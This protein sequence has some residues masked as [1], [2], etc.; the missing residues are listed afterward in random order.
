MMGSMN[1]RTWATLGSS[2][3]VIA[4]ISAPAQAQ[5][6]AQASPPQAA[7]PAEDNAPNEIIVTA[8]KRSE[9]LSDVGLTIS[10][11][12]GDT[13]RQAAVLSAAD[14]PRLVPGLTYARSNTGLPVYTLRGVG[15][16]ETSLAAYPAVT[17]YVDQ[18]PLAFPLLTSHTGLDL[19]RVEVLKGP[20]GILFGQNSTGGAID[21]VAAKPTSTP[22][23]GFDL[24]Y[25]RF[26]RAKAE[27]FVS[28]PLSSTLRARIAGSIE[29][30]SDWQYSYTRNDTLGK[31]RTYNG[32]ILLDWAPSDAVRFE[33]NVN[34][35]VDH[36]DPQAAQ[37]FKLG[38]QLP[39]TAAL[40]AYPTAP[41]N[42]RAADWG[43][44]ADR[45]RGDQRLFQT[46]L[47]AEFDIG[48]ATITSLTSRV[49]AKR[50]DQLDPDGMRLQ[51]YTLLA[52]GEINDFFQELRIANE[53]RNRLRYT[54]GANYEKSHV[55]DDGFLTFADSTI[56]P[57]YG[58]ATNGLI[59]D[60][61]ISSKAVFGNLDFD[62][63]PKLTLK[64]G[65]RYTKTKRS[66]R[67]CTYDPGDGQIAAVFTYF[68]SL[69]RG[70][71]TPPIGP[72][73][74]TSLGPTYLPEQFVG[75]LNEHN[76]SWRT[77]LDYHLAPH[78]LLYVNIAK[79]YK[80][81][82]FPNVAA[83]S[84]AQFLPVVQESVLDYEA[85]FKVE[86]AHRVLSL[87]GAVFYYDYANKQLRSK[88]VDP[89]F[90]VLDKLDNIPKSSVRGAE[91]EA[92]L[93]PSRGFRT[94][95]AVTYLD[96]KIDKFVGVNGAGVSSNFAGTQMP[97]APRWSV[98]GSTD[99]EWGVTSGL[100]ASFGGS[101][102]HNS[103]TY[104]V[105]GNDPDSRIKAYTLVDLRAGLA[106]SSD[107][108]RAQVFVKNLANTYYWTNAI[109]VYDQKVRYAGQPRT[110]G[111]SLSYRY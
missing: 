5:S 107:R 35:W 98:T 103:A 63:T 76:L 50:N 102:T 43:T 70:T 86:L 38:P 88:Y 97:F 95:A 110:Y 22:H 12:T 34:G 79:G 21:F 89:V 87:N 6:A 73:G 47:R 90:R 59:S 51:G 39:P 68:S 2:A 16:Y 18:A 96:G 14:L 9:R 55:L 24:S 7:A 27:A 32:R 19:E 54:V 83:S 8:Q 71:P 99:Y 48:G 13:L 82:S 56:P 65:A 72:G 33:V 26:N 31:I 61:H 4:A 53:A 101:L 69:V 78:A 20:Q 100:K 49:H 52:R 104:S 81:G 84:N 62:V 105:V 77:G 92:V 74:C 41:A 80:A 36:S 91:L 30:G 45:P 25:G 17:V 29:R 15:F 23:Y 75:Q 40:L 111:V 58:F 94:S 46:A 11:F 1:R 109:V 106:A 85:G 60:Q 67:G 64:V 66:D 28:G 57:V 108:W 42:P 37:F 3:A 10:A 44:G 93:T